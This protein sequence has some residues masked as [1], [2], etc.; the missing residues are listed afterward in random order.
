MVVGAMSTYSDAEIALL[1]EYGISIDESAELESLRKDVQR[2]KDHCV[3]GEAEVQ[4]LREENARLRL[5][6]EFAWNII[7]N[8]DWTK[9]GD[10]WR[11]A[12]TG[13]RDRYFA[14]AEA[15]QR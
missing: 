4:R 13:W 15:R 2:W 3:T 14:L 12:A 1:K 8:A 9:E 5:E 11:R 10:E 6:M 7:S